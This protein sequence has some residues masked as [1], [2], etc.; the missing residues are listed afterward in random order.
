VV[1]RPSFPAFA[2][3]ARDLQNFNWDQSLRARES[4][5]PCANCWIEIG[6][7]FEVESMYV[8]EMKIRI[9]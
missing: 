6:L 4:R 8:M 3:G 2:G 5:L 7:N 1:R 9:K